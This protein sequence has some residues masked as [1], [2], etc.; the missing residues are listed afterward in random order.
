MCVSDASLPR[1]LLLLTA[2]QMSESREDSVYLAK[3][4]E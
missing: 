3:L 4:A 2:R 1:F